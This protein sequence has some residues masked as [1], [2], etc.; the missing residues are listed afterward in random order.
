V[1]TES[2]SPAELADIVEEREDRAN[3]NPADYEALGIMRETWA[4]IAVLDKR[5]ATRYLFAL[6]ASGVP[7]LLSHD[8]DGK[9]W[10]VAVR[11][12]LAANPAAWVVSIRGEADN[13]A[14][15]PGI[16]GSQ[17]PQATR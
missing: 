11:G 12:G 13:V 6:A 15:C 10:H 4:C 7:A 9:R 5:E 8:A 17:H 16:A 2:L 1:T 3:R 14:T